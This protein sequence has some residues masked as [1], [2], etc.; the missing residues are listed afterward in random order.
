[1][2]QFCCNPL[3]AEEASGLF[4]W[5]G[6][7]C[8]VLRSTLT[9]HR[10]LLVAHEDTVLHTLPV[11]LKQVSEGRIS[12]DAVTMIQEAVEKISETGYDVAVCWAEQQDELA[13]IIRIRKARPELP[14]LLLTQREDADFLGLA[15][16]MGATRVALLGPDPTE[17]SRSI[18]DILSTGE[19][20][21]EAK[22]Q[23][24]QGRAYSKEIL[25]LARD[26]KELARKATSA[27]P[28]Q[29]QTSFTPLLVE[30]DPDQAFMMVRAFSKADIF[31][32][33]PI[34]KDGEEAIAYLSGQPPFADPVK[35]PL[36]SLLILDLH[37]PKKSGLEVLEWT[38]SFPALKGIPVVLLTSSSDPEH[39]NR[40]YELGASSY[41]IKPTGFNALVELVNGL[42]RWWGATSQK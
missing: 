7:S 20:A 37:L 29:T 36:P 14:I 34:M 24:V 13:G 40:A 18:T 26:T 31:A 22:A 39:I 21:R 9:N 35:Y 12:V 4:G 38:R 8:T 25:N 15:R 33:L 19:L 32:P 3:E 5:G 16:Q 30:D 28:P 1:M 41:L 11:S 10:L 23:A 6:S 17:V 27:L 2:V 42:K